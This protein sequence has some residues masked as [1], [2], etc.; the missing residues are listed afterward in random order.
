[1]LR[2]SSLIIA[3]ILIVPLLDALPNIITAE[4]TDGDATVTLRLLRQAITSDLK[5]WCEV[6]IQVSGENTPFTSGDSV[7]I[8]VREDDFVSDDLL[9]ETN[10]TVTSEEVAAGLVDRTFDCSFDFDD[11]EEGDNWEVF[12]EALVDKDSF[13]DDHPTTQN[14]DVEKVDD[15][16]AEDDDTE[17]TAAVL[18]LE[19]TLERIARDGDWFWFT[20]TEPAELEATLTFIP[21]CG[22]LDATFYP[23]GGSPISASDEDDGAR[24][25]T[26]LVGAGD[27]TIQVVPRDSGDFNFYDVTVSVTLPIFSDGFETGNSTEWSSVVGELP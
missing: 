25:T 3:T 5:S 13:F 23:T 27:H 17:G 6:Q 16:N 9:W 26:G 22:R 8:W 20:L 12:A 10:F 4:D 24:I 1:M 14:L 15:D 11:N 2:K 19:T 21:D 18:T 7:S